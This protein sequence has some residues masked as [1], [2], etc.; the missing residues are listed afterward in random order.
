MSALVST[1]WLA[2]HLNDPWVRVIDASWHMAATKRDPRAEFAA[3]HIPSAQFFDLDAFSDK[4]T[5][6][7]HMMP[8]AGLFAAGMGLLGVGDEH[9]V[10]AYDTD[11]IYSA[12]RLWW[13]LRA[14]GH[15]KAAVLDG[16][17]AKWRRERHPIETGTKHAT[18]ATFTARP[19]ARLI[20]D[21]KDV[22]DVLADKREQVLDARSPSRFTGEEKEP[23]PGLRSGHMPGA[24]NVHYAELVASDGTL[25]PKDELAR[26]FASR[27]VDVNKPA[28]TSCGSGVTA[29]LVLLALNEVG[30]K[31]TSLYDGS[32]AEWG[33]RPDAPIE[34]G[35]AVATGAP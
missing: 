35:A 13:M 29:S 15:D 8:Q 23:R 24:K 17:L 25:R 26:V 27:G 2:T 19:E 14:F 12:P 21:F 30:A 11:G 20:R 33:G 3:A 28:I 34:T 9:F 6:L 10:V 16:G 31:Q 22:R 5:D 18:P 1:D 4:S 32:W 7:P